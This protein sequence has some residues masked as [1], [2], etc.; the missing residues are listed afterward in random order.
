MSRRSYQHAVGTL[1][2]VA[3]AAIV[4]TRIS[5]ARESGPDQ[6]QSGH[7]F[8][9][10]VAPSS[11]DDDDDFRIRQGFKIA[12]VP[13]NL[14]GKN[15]KLVGLGSYIVN[16]VGDCGGCHT[17]PAYAP[18]GDPFMGETEQ[19]N[20][21]NYLAGGAPFFGPFVPRNLTPDPSKGNRPAGLTRREF[22]HIINTGEDDEPPILGFDT[23][24]QFMPWPTFRKMSDHELSAIYE[25]L[26]AIPH[27]EPAPMP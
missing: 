5:V 1:L 9:G 2:L 4:L 26:S 21:D 14:R 7:Q 19:I 13:L 15:A 20:T 23:L 24:L 27:A 6:P 22:L 10:F 17:F 18:G 8:P 11:H 3:A 25:Y 16:A 12:P